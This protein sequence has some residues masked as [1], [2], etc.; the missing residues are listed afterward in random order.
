M[1]KENWIKEETRSMEVN[2]SYWNNLKG[3]LM[4]F[5]VIGHFI[6]VY[7]EKCGGGGITIIS[8]RRF[9]VLFIIFTCRFLCLYPAIFQKMW[10]KEEIVLLKIC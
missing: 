5:V 1:G 9:Y 3:L 2:R 4:G 10:K 8:C 6:Q 7:F